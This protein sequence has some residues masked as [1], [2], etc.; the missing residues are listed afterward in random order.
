[1]ENFPC[2]KR[3]CYIK[4]WSKMIQIDGSTKKIHGQDTVNIITEN[5]AMKQQRELPS[6][7]EHISNM[8]LSSKPSGKPSSSKTNIVLSYM[9]EVIKDM[10]KHFQMEK[11]DSTKT[12]SMSSNDQDDNQFS[13][14]A[15]EAQPTDEEL[16]NFDVD[17]VFEELFNNIKDQSRQENLPRQIK[18]KKRKKVHNSHCPPNSIRH[19]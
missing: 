10:Q 1:M 4:F 9:E 2:L 12:M 7:F 6:P 18:E 3:T 19:Y 17:S 8:L 11:G 15:G 14:L 16:K 13:C 5:I